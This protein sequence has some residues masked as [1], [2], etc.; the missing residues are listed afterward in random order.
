MPFETIQYPNTNE[1]NP[2]ETSVHWNKQGEMPGIV[3]I[4]LRRHKFTCGCSPDEDAACSFE[5]CIGGKN[6][7]QD[8]CRWGPPPTSDPEDEIAL[9]T[10]TMTRAEINDMI[11][12]LRK[13]R[14]QAFGRDE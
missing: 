5:G 14:D 3:Q 1:A 4:S 13:A 12:T 10:R 8:S 11:R 6:I 7:G 9:F 2:V